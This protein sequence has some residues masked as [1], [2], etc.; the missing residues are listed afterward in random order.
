[1]TATALMAAGTRTSEG[2]SRLDTLKGY[3]PTRDKGV[4]PRLER[5]INPDADD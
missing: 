5:R 2:R 3:G 4:K 1:M